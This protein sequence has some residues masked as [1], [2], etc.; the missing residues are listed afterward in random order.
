ME[1]Q[2]KIAVTGAS[3]MLGGQMVQELSAS[4]T[5][6]P[7]PPSI[8]LDLADLSAVR[9]FVSRHAP[10]V[11][12]HLAGARDLDPIE[13]DPSIGW[14]SNYLATHNIALAAREQNCIVCYSSTDAVFPGEGVFYE[15]DP[16][17]PITAY[18][19]SKYAGEVVIREK[20]S[21][22]FIL[23]VPWLLGLTGRPERNYLLGVFGKAKKG[24]PI[25]AAGDQITSV[26]S[27]RDVAHAFAIIILT[28][29]WGTY[30]V[31][32]EPPA[33]RAGVVKTA[34]EMA[35]FGPNLVDEKTRYEINR[36]APR[37]GYSLLRSLLLKPVFGLELRTWKD[38]L[39]EDIAQLKKQG[40]I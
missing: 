16:P 3:G 34:L 18:G 31:S 8:E 37:S 39:R 7:F 12:I 25:T 1:K 35:G 40:V 4:H 33:S 30:H 26:C 20:L 38:G 24:E 11:I 17:C 19:R 6:I 23:R 15:F 10:D 32:C 36:P 2:L 14:N 27:I 28:E 13:Q 5:V 22:Y 21:R 29:H 9:E